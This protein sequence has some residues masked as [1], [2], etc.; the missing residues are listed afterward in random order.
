MDFLVELL[1]TMI[2]CIVMVAFAGL[3]VFFG[4]TLRKKKNKSAKK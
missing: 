3:G 2:E 1:R 4:I